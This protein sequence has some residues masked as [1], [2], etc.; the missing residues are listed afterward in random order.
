L[1]RWEGW[2]KEAKEKALAYLLSA[3]EENGSWNNRAYDT[4]VA[5]RAL[6]DSAPNLYVK[7]ISFE[8]S[9]PVEG[10]IVKIKALV[11]NM[12]GE[13][14]KEFAIKLFVGD[15]EIGEGETIASLGVNETKE[16]IV[17][18]DTTGFAGE[19]E[20][21]VKVEYSEREVDKENN[22]ASKKIRIL[23]KPDLEVVSTD[24]TFSPYEP[25]VDDEIKI[26]AIVRNRGE[27]V[28]ENFRAV[29]YDGEPE[30]G[31]RLLH[32]FNVASLSGGS[33]QLL[34]LIVGARNFSPGTHR[35]Y[36]VADDGDNVSESNEKN[37]VAYKEL[38]VFT[39]PDLEPV[40]ITLEP[41]APVEGDKVKVSVEIA[42][43]RAYYLPK[44]LNAQYWQQIKT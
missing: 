35:I 32:S 11:G 34:Q 36:L 30:K 6:W 43:K 8:P 28:A 12:G 7:Q 14:S 15:E 17:D 18:W 9:F 31:G 26:E 5:L 41:E 4:A 37:N 19:Q 33:Y 42:N 2:Q 1:I 20:I 38:K 40:S 21:F 16:V 44:G 27:G 3:Q 10:E 25:L 23:T 22:V 29:L 24:I 13:A 39:L